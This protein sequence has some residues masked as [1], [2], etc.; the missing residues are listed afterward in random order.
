MRRSMIPWLVLIGLTI[1][2]AGFFVLLLTQAQLVW[3]PLTPQ[4]LEAL[5]Q[6]VHP[7]PHQE[8]VFHGSEGALSSR[9]NWISSRL[10][11]GVLLADAKI[12]ERS[13]TLAVDTGVLTDEPILLYAPTAQAVG[14]RLTAESSPLSPPEPG[15]TFP[16]FQGV[17]DKLELGG[18]VAYHVPVRVVAAHHRLKSL[19]LSL[20]SLNGFIGLSFLERFAATWDFEH[21]RLLIRRQPWEGSGLALSLHKAE[22]EHEGERERFYYVEGFL[23]GQGP[24]QVLIDTGASS[25]VLLVAGRVAQAYGQKRFRVRR[26]KLGEIEL[27]DLPAINL[28]AELG[29]EVPIDVIVGTGL[30]RAKGF[31]RLTVD[32]LAAKLYVER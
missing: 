2:F 32:F 20:F 27:E 14:L 22:L 9:W 15:L 28:A 16:T 26:L 7:Q 13:L 4:E 11:P 30:L 24:Y 5:R 29:R 3:E 10:F 21:H 1:V 12:N 23:D 18:L 19:G 25:P 8:L 31:K 6:S 17:A